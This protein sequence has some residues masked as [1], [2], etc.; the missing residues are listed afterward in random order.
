MTIFVL[1]F[2]PQGD[3]SQ[4]PKQEA[5]WLKSKTDPLQPLPTL[6]QA[7]LPGQRDY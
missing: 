1:F 4:N 5:H 3:T 2:A 7:L 6:R